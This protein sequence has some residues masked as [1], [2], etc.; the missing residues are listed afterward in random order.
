MTKPDRTVGQCVR[1]RIEECA[2]DR[3]ERFDPNRSN[4]KRN[5]GL[6]LDGARWLLC[7]GQKVAVTLRRD[8]ARP[9]G[10]PMVRLRIEESPP[11]RSGPYDPKRSNWRTQCRATSRRSEMA[12]LR[13]T[14]KV[15]VTL[16]RDE[17]R[18]DDWPSG[19][20]E[21]RRG[22]PYRSGPYDPKRSNWR[23]Q[24]RATS[25]R[26]EMATLRRHDKK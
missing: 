6:H 24:C 11:Y 3:S 22:A 12:T 20:P 13:R 10:W 16:R 8:E 21:D 17:A 7:G 23:T 18:P 9:D 5:V 14:Q 25:R 26:S 19:S 2:P 1:L 4:W 15:A